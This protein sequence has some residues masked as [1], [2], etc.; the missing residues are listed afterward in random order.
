MT[1]MDQMRNNLTIEK[2]LMEIEDLK[3]QL[4]RKDALIDELTLLLPDEELNKRFN[5]QDGDEPEWE[6]IK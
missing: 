2:L 1:N 6:E 4:I 5:I 3:V